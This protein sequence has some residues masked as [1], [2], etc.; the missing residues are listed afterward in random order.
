MKVDPPG[1]VLAFPDPDNP[2]GASTA[3]VGFYDRQTSVTLTAIAAQGKTFSAWSGDCT[4]NAN[5]GMV[6]VGPNDRSVTATFK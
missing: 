2:D 1:A 3:G 6:T 4:G 5:T